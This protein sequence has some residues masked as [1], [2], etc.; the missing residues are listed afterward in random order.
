M[1]LHINW[2]HPHL[3]TPESEAAKFLE[4]TE[5][6]FLFQ[7]VSEVTR[8]RGDDIP[9]LLDVVL[10]NEE[11]MVSNVEHLAPL[12]KSDHQTLL[13]QFN[14]YADFSKPSMKHNYNRADLDGAREALI[15]N[16]LH[17]DGTVEEMWQQ[18]KTRLHEIRDEFVPLK[19]VGT[20]KWKADF[21]HDG[22]IIDLIKE[23]GRLH[24][25]W[26]SNKFNERGTELRKRYNRARNHVRKRTRQLKKKHES[27]IAE[28]A[29]S[30]PK[31]FY[32]H[33]RALLKTRTGVAP[34]L[35][36]PEDQS[37]LTFEDSKKADILERQ[38][39]SV[40]TVEPDGDIPILPDHTGAVIE[41]LQ[42]NTEEVLKRLKELNPSKSCGP[43][44]LPPRLL[45]E[46]AH[47]L[48]EPITTLF[49]AS[50]RTSSVPADWKTANITSVFKK[51]SKK[52]AENYRPVSLTCI[53]CK[54]LESIVRVAVMEHLS[55]N[56][57]IS[58]KQYGFLPGRS[59]TLQLL[60]YIDFCT[61]AIVNNKH[62]DSVY[63]DFSKAFDSVPHRRLLGKLESYGIRGP[64]LGWIRDFLSDR[65]QRVVINGECSASD[66]VVSGVPQGSV[67]GPLLFVIYINDLPDML[68]SPCL[69]FADDSKV[70]RTINSDEDMAA[71]QKDLEALEEWSRTWLLR[72]HPGKCKVI[73]IGESTGA[74]VC[75]H[76]YKL[77]ETNLEHIGEEKD[78][79]VYV[80]CDLKFESH[81]AEQ[82]KKA[83]AMLGL[84]RR[85][86]TSLSANI[87]LP[88]FKCFV[89]HHL[90]NNAVVWGGNLSKRQIDAIE[91]VQIRATAMIEGMH[92]MDYSE[93]LQR[94]KLPTLV[95]RRARG[96]MIEVWRHFHSHDNSVSENMFQL[97]VSQRNPLQIRRGPVSYSHRNIQAN[98]F[99]YFAPLAWNML[100]SDI[101]TASKMDTFKARLD[102]TWEKHMFMYNY[103]QLVTNINTRRDIDVETGLQDA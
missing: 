13:F 94:L 34:L 53:L 28:S 69:M 66:P 83:S 46:L 26:M 44:D 37:T 60:K 12:G 75:G 36:N 81:V 96:R 9:S 5:E 18:L 54:M 1:N 68:N 24:R 65:T 55:R 21:P 11:E 67:L 80:D 25:Q 77:L 97:A 88:L 63:L 99:Y 49:N 32:A 78:L 22:K 84:I 98:S 59:T 87:V 52:I 6:L 76:P 31:A 48:A 57:L 102:K 39:S 95:Y 61:G 91:K 100:D 89:R 20:S 50:L 45:R 58:D 74:H 27:T 90:E 10:T 40:F 101:R 62:V 79:G 42:T 72:F 85:S 64:L 70:F 16:P 2:A 38:F 3:T 56:N 4:T 51:G 86:F 19:K 92:M 29:K 17:L 47:E 93:R 7:H 103:E 41:G 35:S 30:N 15:Q 43:D 8:C 14:C 73:S 71:L 23:K 33:T 82:V